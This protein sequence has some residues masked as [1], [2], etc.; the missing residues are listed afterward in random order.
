MNN[1]IN[2]SKQKFTV[3]LKKK[4]LSTLLHVNKYTYMFFL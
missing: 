2:N 4:N 3:P 1:K